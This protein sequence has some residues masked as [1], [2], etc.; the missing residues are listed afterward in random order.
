MDE[1]TDRPDRDIVEVTLQ[2]QRSDV[3]DT[4]DQALWVVIRNSSPALSFAKYARFYETE[5]PSGSARTRG[6][7]CVVLAVA[8]LLIGFLLGAVGRR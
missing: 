4:E 8:F 6:T 2:R 5:P 3:V 7:R 1:R